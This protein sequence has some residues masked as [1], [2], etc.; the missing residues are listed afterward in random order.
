MHI[1]TNAQNCN[2]L[3]VF[4]SLRGSLSCQWI[5]RCVV[6]SLPL[7]HSL[8]LFSN[9]L[10]SEGVQNKD[11]LLTAGKWKKTISK[12][13]GKKCELLFGI[14]S[15]KGDFT[16]LILGWGCLVCWRV[17]VFIIF[18]HFAQ[19][20]THSPRMQMWSDSLL[21][22][23]SFISYRKHSGV[24]GNLSTFRN[25]PSQTCCLSIVNLGVLAKLNMPDD[26]EMP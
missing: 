4:V 21:P 18:I 7:Y 24:S 16:S 2:F 14:G 25:R 17:F 9:I 10:M 5:V 8:F 13:Q 23:T 6:L 20:F 22:Q 11:F 12:L 26:T 15:E 3:S 1:D 19:I